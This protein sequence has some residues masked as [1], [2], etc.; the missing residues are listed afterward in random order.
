MSRVHVGV[1]PQI[2]FIR[3]ISIVFLLV[4]FSRFTDFT[5][6]FLQILAR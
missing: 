6:W 3:K 1:S 2:E 5:L 4:I